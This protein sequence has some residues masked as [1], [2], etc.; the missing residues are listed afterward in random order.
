M[1][2]YV[3]FLLLSLYIQLTIA[4]EANDSLSISYRSGFK[5]TRLNISESG[6]YEISNGV[7]IPLSISADEQLFQQDLASYHCVYFVAV[8]KKRKHFKNTVFIYSLDGTLLDKFQFKGQLKIEVKRKKLAFLHSKKN[9]L[10]ID[11][12]IFS[13]VG[14]TDVIRTAISTNGKKIAR[15]VKHKKRKL[16]RFIRRKHRRGLLN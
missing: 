2:K 14:D 10:E 4:Q 7:K 11:A 1:K 9:T 5:E 3:F 6:T 15:F 13:T 8:Q 12:L 16:K